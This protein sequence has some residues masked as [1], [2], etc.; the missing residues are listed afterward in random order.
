MRYLIIVTLFVLS[1]CISNIEKNNDTGL[2][3]DIYQ[4]DM[5]Y[6]KFKQYAIDYAEKS[7]YPNL[8]NK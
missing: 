3:I 2:N 8:S 4:S 5:T 6:E 7:P 1:S